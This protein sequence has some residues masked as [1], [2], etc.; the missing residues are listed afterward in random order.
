MRA[1]YMGKT[2]SLDLGY[3]SFWAASVHYVRIF[4]SQ[5]P[6]ACRTALNLYILQTVS[7]L[8]ITSTQVQDL[9]LGRVE[10]CDAN[11]DSE[12]ERK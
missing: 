12:A 2:T 5:I 7:I 4:N 10:P 11:A 6:S 9:A 8:R 3:V 1:K